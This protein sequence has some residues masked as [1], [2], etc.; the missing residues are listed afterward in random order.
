MKNRKLVYTLILTLVLISFILAGIIFSAQNQKLRVFFLDVGQGDA[1][2]IMQGSN[3]ILIDGGPSGQILLEKL[4]KY[5]PFWDREIE[6]V[7]ATHPDQDHI[8]GLVDVLKN[9]KVDAL[10][11]T[12]AQSESQVYKKLEEIMAGKNIAKIE[13]RAG[14][15]IKLDQAELNILSPQDQLPVEVVKDTNMYSIVAKLVFGQ[16]SFLFTGDL[17]STEELKL[18]QDGTD[19]SA[20]VLKV[21]HHGSKYS[22]SNE[23]LEKVRPDW[24]II[25]VGKNNRYGHPSSDVLD[26]LRTHKINIVRTDEKGDITY[27]CQ[28]LNA[29]CQMLTD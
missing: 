24:A 26:R 6:M 12:Q 3:Q 7:I 9:Y 16:N 13:G 1:T 27:K 17:P 19:L 28:N 20:K 2:L 5:I 4:G 29:K 8:E 21:G 10:M 25:S 15:K 23:F 18:I 22:T 11:E 14:A